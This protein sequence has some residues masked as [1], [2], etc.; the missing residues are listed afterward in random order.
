MRA[1]L[2]RTVALA[3]RLARTVAVAGLAFLLA[4]TAALGAP[5]QKKGLGIQAGHFADWKQR[6]ELAKVSWFYTWR[7]EAPGEVQGVEFVPMVWGMKSAD[8]GTIAALK[9]GRDEGRY[10]SLLGFNEPD[11]K[12]QSN[13]PA[14]EALELWRLLEST[15]L[16]MG[17]PATVNAHVPWMRKFIAGA[18]AAKGRVDFI[19]VHW[20]GAAAD[21]FLKHLEYVHE[22]YKRPIWITEFAVADWGARASGQSRYTAEQALQFMQRAVPALERMPYVERY[23]WFSGR[24]DNPTISQSLL[25]GADGK[26]TPLGRVYAGY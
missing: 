3:A 1:N 26:L 16:R 22:R 21:K 19:A 24:P 7:A 6:L 4:G 25:F 5:S 8:A 12:G 11:A 20:Y 17:S 15:G 9:K 13:I 10:K 18:E 23:A 2:F 14:E